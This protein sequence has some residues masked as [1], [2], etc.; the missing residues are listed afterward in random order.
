VAVL[1]ASGAVSTHETR[2]QPCLVASAAKRMS[3]GFPT[4]DCEKRIDTVRPLVRPT[5]AAATRRS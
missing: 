1:G 2:A 3:L 4:E 5:M